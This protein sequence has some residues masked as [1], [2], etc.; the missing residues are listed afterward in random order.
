MTL[1]EL[2]LEFVLEFG[3][4]SSGKLD[5]KEVTTKHDYKDYSLIIHSYNSMHLVDG[6]LDPLA[7]LFK[8]LIYEYWLKDKIKIQEKIDGVGTEILNIIKQA[9]LECEEYYT[10]ECLLIPF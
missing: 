7:N 4:D 5:I 2:T 10:L 6:I 1:Y 9:L 3:R 8:G